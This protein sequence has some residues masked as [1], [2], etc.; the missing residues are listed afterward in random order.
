MS[1]NY[2]EFLCA[3]FKAA[4]AVVGY[5][6]LNWTPSDATQDYKGVMLSYAVGVAKNC[7]RL[8]IMDNGKS[9]M[10]ECQR[11]FV[12]ACLYEIL[13][14]KIVQLITVICPNRCENFIFRAEIFQK[15]VIRD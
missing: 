2:S 15:N 11:M 10:E 7:V 5:A 6:A 8:I 3:V 12:T 4:V 14:A 9:G 1:G 13:L